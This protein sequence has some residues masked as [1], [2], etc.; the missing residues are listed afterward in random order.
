VAKRGSTK[1]LSVAHED[2]VAWLYRGRRSPS[3]GGAATDRGDVRCLDHLF[4]CKMTGTYEK[5]KRSISLKLDDMEKIA[6]EA[7]Q[8]GKSWAMA[9]RFYAPGS[10]VADKD[11]FVD[12]TLRPSREDAEREL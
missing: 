12:V 4:E 7:Q 6:D 8:E 11:G 5:P 2:W 1:A 10:P 3:S 9:I